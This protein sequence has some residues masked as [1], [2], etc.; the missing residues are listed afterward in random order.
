MSLS[1]SVI[2]QHQ[3]VTVKGDTL[4]CANV[5]FDMEMDEV[6]CRQFQT[7]S[8]L[9]FRTD[10]VSDIKYHFYPK[11]PDLKSPR[12]FIHSGISIAMSNYTQAGGNI[13]T[14]PILADG[15]KR[16]I[17]YSLGIQWY[18]RNQLGI[19][20]QA[21]YF[22]F[23]NDRDSAWAEESIKM[24][25]AGIA[26]CSPNVSKELFAGAQLLFTYADYQT[27]GKVP[28]NEFSGHDNLWGLHLSG[29]LNYHITQSLLL[30]FSGKMHLFNHVPLES[31]NPKINLGL[32][33]I[34]MGF[35]W[36]F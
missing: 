36:I 12:L 7:D 18:T 26:W 34:G 25:G 14:Q 31:E 13:T 10:D 8:V 33:E 17:G 23:K 28:S 5:E 2:G 11:Y 21:G 3:V 30:T 9:S 32:F 29:S 4:N 15:L 22:S 24:A 27:K 19:A 35:A 16:G 20:V 6:R 1:F